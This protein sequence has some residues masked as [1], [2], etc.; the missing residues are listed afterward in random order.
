VEIQVLL[1][2]LKTQMALLKFCLSW[3]SP[4]TEN[5]HAPERL[6]LRLH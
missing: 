4:V 2:S 3:A 1:V 6:V 5:A